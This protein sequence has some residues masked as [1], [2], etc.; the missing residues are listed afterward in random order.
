MEYIRL[1][2]G[3][4]SCDFQ[5]FYLLSL[6]K[7]LIV[8]LK[9]SKFICIANNHDKRSKGLQKKYIMHYLLHYPNI[10]PTYQ[11]WFWALVHNL[12]RKT[13]LIWNV[14]KHCRV[15]QICNHRSSLK[16]H[17]EILSYNISDFSACALLILFLKANILQNKLVL[18]H[19][20]KF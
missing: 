20:N 17:P 1:C 11:Y 10:I 5:L 9:L 8:T 15:K 16:K 14:W 6:D 19:E 3:Q 12:K 7:W 2:T 13:F 18:L 4:K